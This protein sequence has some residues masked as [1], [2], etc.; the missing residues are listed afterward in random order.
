MGPQSESYRIIS[1]NQDSLVNQ[2]SSGPAV[3]ISELP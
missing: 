1:D 2:N 3:S